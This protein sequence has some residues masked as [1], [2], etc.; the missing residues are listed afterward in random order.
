MDEYTRHP[1]YIHHV[2]PLDDTVR[3]YVVDNPLPQIA[4]ET[5]FPQAYIPIHFLMK[6]W[7]LMDEAGIKPEVAYYGAGM[8][9]ASH[10][11]DLQQ[12]DYQKA[13]YDHPPQLLTIKTV[14]YHDHDDNNI[15][16][17]VSGLR[18]FQVDEQIDRDIITLLSAHGGPGH[19][20]TINPDPKIFETDLLIGHKLGLVKPII[21]KDQIR[22]VSAIYYR[23]SPDVDPNDPVAITASPF[24]MVILPRRIWEETFEW[25]PSPRSLP[26]HPGV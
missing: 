20:H 25:Y 26:L 6:A 18:Q 9:T 19:N 12:F 21:H 1:E 10:I 13:G 16:G 14:L 11:A 4:R 23:Y 7:Q 17:L 8:S 22:H 15:L 2:F 3:Q 24:E 5:A